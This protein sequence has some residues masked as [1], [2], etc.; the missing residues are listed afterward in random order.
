MN[1]SDL[2]YNPKEIS[3]KIIVFDYDTT[4]DENALNIHFTKSEF[5]GHRYVGYVEYNEKYPSFIDI[6]HPYDII[7]NNIDS[8]SRHMHINGLKNI[9]VLN[10]NDEITK[11]WARHYLEFHNEVIA[12]KGYDSCEI[13]EEVIKKYL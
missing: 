5:N 4:V 10:D 3:G 7:E 6:S 13:P 11:L 2:R 12:E 8:G 9:H 1:T